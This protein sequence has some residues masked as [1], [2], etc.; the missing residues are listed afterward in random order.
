MARFQLKAAVSPKRRLVLSAAV[1]FLIAGLFYR[2]VLS[3][4][5]DTRRRQRE[6]L[7]SALTRSVICCY[8]LE[9]FYPESLSY[10][11]DHYGLVYNEALFYVDYQPSGANIFPDITIIETED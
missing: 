6:A 1:F 10:L 5:S 11:R 8:A 4:S 3:F 9:G 7:E 2:G